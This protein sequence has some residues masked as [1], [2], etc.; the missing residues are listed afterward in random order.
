MNAQAL[1][2]QIRTPWLQRI[3]NSMARGSEVRDNFS[4]ELE[5]FFSLLEQA[6]ATG[7]PAWLDSVL[8]EWVGAPTQTDLEQ[9]K[10]NVSLLLNKMI[11]VTNQVAR[12]KYNDTY[13]TA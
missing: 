1:L 9:G 3:A 4:K 11:E 8:Y 6:L 13:I 7:D 12:G 10:Y 5:Q 2:T